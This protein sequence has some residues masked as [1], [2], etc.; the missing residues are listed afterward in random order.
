MLLVFLA[1]QIGKIRRK[2][3]KS[4][5]GLRSKA[6]EDDFGYDV[7]G[8]DNPYELPIYEP[9]VYRDS[10]LCNEYVDPAANE[11]LE[12]KPTQFDPS[13]GYLILKPGSGAVVKNPDQTDRNDWNTETVDL[14][15]HCH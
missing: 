13:Y 10:Q 4:E 3:A 2:M 7:D 5:V 8:N 6:N 12:I 9:V 14:I 1:I 15:D 11:Y